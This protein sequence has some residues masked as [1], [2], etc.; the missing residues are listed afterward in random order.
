MVYYLILLR[1]VGINTGGVRGQKTTAA[2]WCF[3]RD[4]STVRMAVARKKELGN[5]MLTDLERMSGIPAYRISRYL[6]KRKPH[7]NQFQLFHLCDIL[8]IDVKLNVEFRQ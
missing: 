4:N 6:L 1:K 7:M 8:G 2:K 3:F 5:Y